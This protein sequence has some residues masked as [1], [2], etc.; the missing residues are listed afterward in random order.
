MLGR[1]TALISACAFALPSGAWAQ[2]D[3]PDPAGPAGVEYELPLDRA[4]DG[5]DGDDEPKRRRPGDDG[6]ERA[7]LFGEGIGSGSGS[8]DGGSATESGGGDGNDGSS[9]GAAGGSGDAGGSG[10]PPGAVDPEGAARADGAE[11]GGSDIGGSKAENGSGR[12]GL[13][14]DIASDGDSTAIQTGGIVLAVLLIGT[15]LG[16]GLRRGLRDAA[17]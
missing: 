17:S 2:S 3:R 9:G 13:A 16:V 4:R 15:L 7:P 14:A 8:T 10:G 12:A 6:R 11:D 1:G 5:A